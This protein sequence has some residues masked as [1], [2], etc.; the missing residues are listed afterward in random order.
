M[1]DTAPI[2]GLTLGSDFPPGD[3]AQWH[4]LVRKVLKGAD[5]ERRLVR[6]TVDGIEIRPLYTATDMPSE[7]GAPGSVPHVRGVGAPTQGDD[8]WDIRQLEVVQDPAVANAAILDGL[9]NG[10]TSIQLR[11]QAPPDAELLDQAL[12]E[13]MLDLAPVALDARADFLPAA[14]ALL[15]VAARRGVD[16]DSLHA[17]LNADPLGAALAGAAL[18]PAGGLADAVRLARL[19]ATEWPA[20]VGLLADG[21]PYHAGG[22]SEAQE[23]AFAVATGIAY[24][25]AIVEAGLP[26]DIAAG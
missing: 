23:L 14:T 20:A 5:F 26:A 18:D 17:E 12:A 6:T 19:I 24:L 1:T 9:E 4:A 21:R 2:E 3:A 8:G 10:A 25:R 11:F 16:R 22:A 15:Q 13:A 7:T